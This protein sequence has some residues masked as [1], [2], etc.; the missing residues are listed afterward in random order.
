MSSLA[1]RC[2][3]TPSSFCSISVAISLKSLSRHVYCTNV[4]GMYTALDRRERSC[5]ARKPEFRSSCDSSPNRAGEYVPK[6]AC[7]ASSPKSP[8]NSLRPLY[9]VPD[10]ISGAGRHGNS[11]GRATCAVATSTAPTTA[12]H[13]APRRLWYMFLTR[14]FSFFKKVGS[15]WPFI[16]S[17][18]SFSSS[19]A[20]FL[21]KP[22]KKP[23]TKVNRAENAP[24][25]M[26]SKMMS[27][28]SLGDHP[29]LE[30]GSVI[31]SD[32]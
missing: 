12:S 21:R 6:P 24:A 25:I 10:T 28:R 20:P 5:P 19:S 22:P 30:S 2:F 31:T 16:D 1:N 27:G 14:R 7:P 4:R 8:P 32:E 26:A 11:V 17:S 15:F 18:L 9:A 3:T 29:V 23:A 13:H